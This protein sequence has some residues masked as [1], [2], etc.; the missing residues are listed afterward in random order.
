MTQTDAENP[1][2][3]RRV[4]AAR[5][6]AEILARHQNLGLAIGRLVSSTKSGFLAAVLVKRISSKQRLPNPVRWMVLQIL[7]GMIMSVSTLKIMFRG[8]A[9]PSSFVN[10]SMGPAPYSFSAKVNHPI[11]RPQN[12]ASDHRTWCCRPPACAQHRSG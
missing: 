3:P 5:A 4:F 6:A 12:R 9:T 2:A 11:L 10:G 1:A 7:L 8:A